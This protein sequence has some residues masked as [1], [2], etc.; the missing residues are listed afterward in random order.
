MAPTPSAANRSSPTDI[1]VFAI[2]RT[3]T[4]AECG[5]E[6]WRGNFLRIEHDR[7]LCMACADLDRLVF[8]PSGDAALTRRARKHSTLSAV[9]LRF[10]RA[11]KRHERQGLLVEEEAL[12]QAERECMEDAEARAGARRR[13]AERRAEEDT[14]HA[15]A[16]ARH[17]GNR[18]P[19]CPS[20]ERTT[21]ARHACRRHSGRVGRSAAAKRLDP[22][23]VDLAVRAHV[24]HAH[25]RYDELLVLGQDRETAR[26][27][28]AADMQEVLDGW[29]K[30][31]DSREHGN[32]VHQAEKQN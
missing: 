28:V 12:D 14:E 30:T 25:T 4:C 17:L 6:L 26:A 8:L 21:I 15:N 16:F 7:P 27:H 18:Y 22:A 19:G 3:A 5:A 13:A 10:S 20:A 24:R 31:P 2:T 23:A 32:R 11:R 1:V 9:V 29:R